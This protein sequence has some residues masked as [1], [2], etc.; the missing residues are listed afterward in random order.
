[1]VPRGFD[2]VDSGSDVDGGS[3]AGHFG[4]GVIEQY[5]GDRVQLFLRNVAEAV[6]RFCVDH[7]AGVQAAS[8]QQIIGRKFA[9]IVL[10]GASGKVD[11]K[12]ISRLPLQ[13]VVSSGY[14]ALPSHVASRHAGGSVGFR[15][16][17]QQC[18]K[19]VVTCLRLTQVGGV[20]G[21][22]A[23]GVGQAPRQR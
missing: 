14:L 19:F 10:R 22:S 6:Y 2:A 7:Q 11:S 16:K 12:R 21:V 4:S 18:R 3:R 1:M 8:L 5:R 13:Y 9:G 20:I 17:L 15:N 23:H